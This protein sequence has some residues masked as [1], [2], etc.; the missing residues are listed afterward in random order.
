MLGIGFAVLLGAGGGL[1][2]WKVGSP[3]N[4]LLKFSEECQSHPALP[5]SCQAFESEQVREDLLIESPPDSRMTDAMV[6]LSSAVKARTCDHAV[7]AR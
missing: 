7:V 2:W 6:K 3:L 4:R 5:Q 1:L